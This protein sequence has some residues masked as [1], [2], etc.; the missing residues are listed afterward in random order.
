MVQTLASGELAKLVLPERLRCDPDQKGP[1]ETKFAPALQ[2]HSPRSGSHFSGQPCAH[3][4]QRMRFVHPRRLQGQA[5]ERKGAMWLVA[6][7]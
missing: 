3:T 1:P 4:W 2:L 6:L 7:P 5:R